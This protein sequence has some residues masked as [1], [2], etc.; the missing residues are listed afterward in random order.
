MFSRE[1][2]YG[3]F[4]ATLYKRYP[5]DKR[6]VTQEWSGPMYQ[7]EV[8][9]VRRFSLFGRMILRNSMLLFVSKKHLTVKG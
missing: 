1:K 6:T 4:F 7:K 3:S 2:V 8:A 5:N 9:P